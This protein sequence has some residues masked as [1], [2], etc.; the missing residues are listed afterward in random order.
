MNVRIKLKMETPDASCAFEVG[1]TLTVS[2][3]NRHTGEIGVDLDPSVFLLLEGRKW[4]D[5][6]KK[7]SGA[8]VTE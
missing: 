6:I 4:L 1:Q 8:V 5:R 3:V 2:W 7:F